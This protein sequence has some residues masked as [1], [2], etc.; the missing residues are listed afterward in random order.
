[1][2][3]YK[4]Y[5]KLIKEGLLYTHNIQKYYGSLDI[6]LNGIG[7]KHNINIISKFLYELEILNSNELSNDILK[8]VVNLNQ[9]LLGYI[10]SYI[11]VEN[12]FGINSF[13]FDKKY[14][15]NKYKNIKIRFE[16]KYEDGLYKN[17]LDVPSI[18]YHLSPNS[19]KVKIMTN[20]LYPKSKNRKSY[21]SERIYLFYNLDDY[22]FL[23][24]SL[25]FN[26]KINN[27][28]TNYILYKIKMNDN[29]IIHTDPNYDKG[30][31]TYDNISPNDIEIVKENL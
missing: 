6:E 29:M 12:D 25:K 21:Y 24:K 30:F 11:W 15:S 17:D 27:I 3:N 10:P 14:L 7:V 19:H 4:K 5:I 1:M 26:D 31:Y 9:N 13:N 28:N 20:G 8:F 22:K 23:L 16:A 18:A 2:I